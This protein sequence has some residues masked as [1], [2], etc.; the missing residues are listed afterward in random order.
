MFPRKKT[1]ILML[2]A[3]F[4][5]FAVGYAVREL[6]DGP[7]PPTAV[8]I[9]DGISIGGDFTLTDHTGKIVTQ[10]N[11]KGEFLLIYFGYTFCPDV[12]PTELQRMS[13]VLRKLGTAADRVRPVFITID[14][15]R[16]TAKVLAEYVGNF[17]PRMVGLTGTAAQ[18]KAV[19][20][21]YGVSFGKSWATETGKKPP[22]MSPAQA[23]KEYFMSHTSFVYLM[24]D[25]GRVRDI[26]RADVKDENMVKRILAALEG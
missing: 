9:A 24:G 8:K 20:K 1:L 16:D 21:A 4:T 2:V 18:I 17:H 11:F 22:G 26:F 3:G 14:P 6:V 19:A 12:C 25:D 13:E 23:E 15:A 5:A 10:E 7:P